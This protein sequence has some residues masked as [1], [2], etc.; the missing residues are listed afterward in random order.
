M[1]DKTTEL[2]GGN[3]TYE[4]RGFRI[5]D[6]M[7][8]ALD[9]YVREGLAPG[10]FLRAVLCNDLVEAAGRA[11]GNNARNLVAY[12]GFMYNVMPSGCWGSPENVKAWIEQR[13]LMAEPYAAGLLTALKTAQDIE[14]E[15]NHYGEYRKLS[16]GSIKNTLTGEV[17]E[18]VSRHITEIGD[19]K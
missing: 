11:D 6:Y 17:A 14:N 1:T 5:P 4:F 12:V 15:I 19:S 3:D 9:R 7:R 16:D 2:F 8:P 18:P 13:G 10:D